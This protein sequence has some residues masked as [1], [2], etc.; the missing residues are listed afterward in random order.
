M[1]AIQGLSSSR[2]LLLNFSISF[3]LLHFVISFW[4]ELSPLTRLCDSQFFFFFSERVLN[5]QRWWF[6][7]S[8]LY[9]F[10]WFITSLSSPKCEIENARTIIK[11]HNCA[12]KCGGFS[13]ICCITCWLI[14]ILPSKTLGPFFFL[15]IN[16]LFF[17]P[18]KSKWLHCSSP[19]P[20]SVFSFFFRT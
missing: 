11:F 20:L 17:S 4:R 2:L 1:S 7:F 15:S 3:F 13:G 5:F 19:N 16:W 18:W 10:L 14:L 6:F 12:S 8:L 9:S